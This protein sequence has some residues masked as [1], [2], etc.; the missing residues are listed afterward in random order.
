MP[1]D[2][3]RIAQTVE[4]MLAGEGRAINDLE[5][6]L[7]PTAHARYIDGVRAGE[8]DRAVIHDLA[9]R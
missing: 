1:S 8:H 9:P 3:V 4:R 5:P 6:A 2:G 7:R